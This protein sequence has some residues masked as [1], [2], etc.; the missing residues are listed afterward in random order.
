MTNTN[1]KH[2]KLVKDGLSWVIRMPNGNTWLRT[3]E[4]QTAA[5]AFKFIED[6]GQTENFKLPKYERA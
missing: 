2:C 1:G 5:E 3:T 4:E 6:G